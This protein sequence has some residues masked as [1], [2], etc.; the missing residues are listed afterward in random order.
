M[1]TTRGNAI[2]R[3]APLVLG[4]VLPGIGARWLER[5]LTS[6]TRPFVL[7][8]A[9]P[10][11]AAG[12]RFRVPH[13]G[14]WLQA[15]QWGTRGPA[16]LLL[17]GWDGYAAQLKAFVD[18]LVAAGFRVVALDAP[19]H[20]DSDGTTTDLV[21]YAAAILAVAG[22]VGPLHGAVAHACAAPALAFAATTGLALDAM[23]LIA[24]PRTMG[25]HARD[26]RVA[27]GLPGSVDAPMR[28]R[29][30]RR[31]G[32]SWDRLALDNLIADI[33]ARVLVVHDRNDPTVP[34]RDGA[35]VADA[36]PRARLITT[37][38]LGH[39]GT[40]DDPDVVDSAAAFLNGSAVRHDIER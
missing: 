5:H 26:L 32:L 23:V 39:L 33:E 18:P 30:E 24:P 31:L 38:G 3:A 13:N 8:E 20:G 17:H 7:T 19:A 35:S 14:G 10:I 4:H 6:P 34:W 11:M 29:L 27:L 40:L 12:H 36:A 37:Q 9:D 15:W 25:G 21:D 22:I 28:R 2:T 1:M 16:I